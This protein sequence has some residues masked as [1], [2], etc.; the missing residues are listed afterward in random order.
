MTALMAFAAFSGLFEIVLTQETIVQVRRN[1]RGVALPTTLPYGDG[2]SGKQG[3][4]GC[5]WLLLG[6][7]R[8]AKP[9]RG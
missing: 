7:E 4:L 6:R 2:I 9:L 1:L 3:M 8:P 5:P